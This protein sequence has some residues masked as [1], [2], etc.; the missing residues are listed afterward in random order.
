MITIS[1]VDYAPNRVMPAHSHETLGISVVMRGL[2]EETAGRKTEIAGIASAVIKP[3]GTVHA[4]RFGPQGAR[5]LAI[6]MSPGAANELLGHHRF[7]GR[8]QWMR[9]MRALGATCRTL[10]RV[11]HV[12]PLDGDAVENLAVEL[13][14]ALD[15]D[16]PASR[17]VAPSWL[18]RVHQRLDED[19]ATPFR[20]RE[21]ASEAGVHPVY[22]ARRFRRHNGCS[23]LEYVR[24]VR[25]RA[26][27]RE[28]ADAARPL[29][30]VAARVGFSDQSHLTRA[31]RATT[32]LTPRAYRRLARPA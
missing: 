18:A 13:V 1:V 25:L 28:L 12:R 6:D 9:V 8:W 23:V 11:S 7:L 32:G 19:F 2:V 4:N 17:G 26:A 27:M 5:L 10:S 14:A 31:L 29:S 21:L 3:P 22:L 24:T 15:G 30:E 16:A 20:V